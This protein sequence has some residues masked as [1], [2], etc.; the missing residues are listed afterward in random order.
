VDNKTKFYHHP[1]IHD[2]AM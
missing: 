2:I 1:N